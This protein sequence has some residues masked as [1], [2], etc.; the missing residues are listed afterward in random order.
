MDMLTFVEISDEGQSRGVWP[1]MRQLRVGLSEGDYIARLRS[2]QT[3]G[4]RLFSLNEDGR[5]VGLI[6]WRIINDLSSGKSLYV[7][8]LIVDEAQRSRNFGHRLIQFARERAEAEQCD[9][10]RLSSALRRVRA[11]AFYEREGFD[12]GGYSFKLT[13]RS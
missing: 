7:D 11:H 3:G 4:Y 2:A 5:P 13:L 1:I 12:K 6:G 8:D 9:A 10:I